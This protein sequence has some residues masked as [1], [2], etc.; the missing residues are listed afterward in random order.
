GRPSQRAEPAARCPPAR[1]AGTRRRRTRMNSSGQQASSGVT[2][3]GRRE[4]AGLAV[5]ALACLLDAMDLTVLHLAVPAI[6]EDLRPSGA[7]L[8]WITA[9]YGFMVAGFLLTMGTLGDRLGRRRVRLGGAACFGVVSVLAAFSTSPEM[10]IGARALLGIGG[11]TLAPSTL[12]LIFI[13]FPDPQQRSTAIGIWITAFSAGGAI[14]PMLGGVLLEQFWWGSVVLLA[15][16]GVALVLVVGP[17]LLPEYRHPGA[18]RLDLVSGALLRVAV[19]AV[20][21]GIK[22]AAATRLSW[23]A[24]AAIL[25]G[26]AV[27]VGFAR[28]QLTLADPMIDLR[29]FRSRAFNASLATNLLGILIVVGYFLFVAQ[30][31]Q[32]VLGLS[33]LEAG[34]WSLPSAGGFIVGSNL[35]PWLLRR[36]RPAYVIGSGLALAA[37]G[38]GVLTRV[39]GSPGADLGI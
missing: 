21:F 30:S 22:E 1:P 10:L 27:G 6:S 16:P 25:G 34:L 14:G 24:A 15:G 8:L 5:L 11:A 37:V 35:A 20:V 9:L 23:A 33:P 36:V 19:L 12:S 39:G 31:L 2:R 29:L 32:L 13:M 26:L 28:R 18:G 3:A 4:W 7:Q 38:L 17:R